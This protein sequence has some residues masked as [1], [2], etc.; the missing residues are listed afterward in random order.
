MQPFQCSFKKCIELRRQ[1]QSLG[2]KHSGGTKRPQP[3]PPH[4][5]GTF[6]RRLQ[7]LYTKKYKVSCS[8][9]L[10][11]TQSMQ[12]SCSYSNAICSHSFKKRITTPTGTTTRCKTHRGNQSRPEQPQPHPLHTGGTFHRRMQPL[13]TEKYKV[14]C[15]GFLPT[16]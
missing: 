14:S 13:Y 8:G 9:F 5:R 7:P 2:A 12:Y 6:H 11:T 10:P 3:Q 16:R 15:A 1:E 4:I